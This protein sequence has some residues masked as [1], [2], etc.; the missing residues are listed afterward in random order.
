MGRLSLVET[1][2]GNACAQMED[3]TG[4][5]L[6]ARFSADGKTVSVVLFNSDTPSMLQS[7]HL[8]RYDVSNL[9]FSKLCSIGQAICCVDDDSQAFVISQEA[10]GRFAYTLPLYTH[11]E[12]LDMAEE[13]TRG[14]ELTAE[15]RQLYGIE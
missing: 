14:H 1:A 7:L 13:V 9:E 11:T 3:S 2:T 6:D 4:L 12:L 15:E 8:D 10:K 5:I